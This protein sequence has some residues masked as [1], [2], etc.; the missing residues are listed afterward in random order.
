MGGA[1][2]QSILNNRP[3]LFSRYDIFDIMTDKSMGFKANKNVRI[4]ESLSSLMEQNDY[5]LLAVKPQVMKDLLEKIKAGK[6]Q[7]KCFITIA[8]GL[9]LALY[10]NILGS[11]C[12]ITRVMPNTPYMVG[13]GAA[14]LVLDPTL[15]EDQAGLIKGIFEASG[16]TYVCEE[17]LIDAVTGLSGSGPAYIFIIIEA[18]ADGGVKMGIPRDQALKLAAQ[19]VLGSAKMVLETQKH[20]GILKDMVCSPGGTTIAGVSVLESGGLRGLLISAVEAATKRAQ[21]LIK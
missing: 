7:N 17:K 15:S 21:E 6:Y 9:P 3:D 12:K 11:D 1:L 2:L 10:R 14:G 8:A 16:K 13:E 20:P 19:T 18:L 5:I 4:I